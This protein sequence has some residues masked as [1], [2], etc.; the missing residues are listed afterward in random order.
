MKQDIIPTEERNVIRQEL[1]IEKWPIFAPS[2]FRGKSREIKREVVLENGDK[3]TRKVIIGKINDTEVGVLRLSDYKIF[4][5]LVKLWE[6][7]GR[8]IKEDVNFTLHKIAGILSIIWGGKTYKEI[9][10]SLIKL[11]AIPIIWEDSFYQKETNTTEKLINCFR[12]LDDLKIFER[13]KDDQMYFAF[14]SFKFNY[15][16]I[17]N[18]LNNY[19][20]PLYLDVIL[21]F[22]K[23]ISVFLYRHL[24]LVMADKNYFE[25][26]TQELFIDLELGKYYPSRRKTLLIPVLEELEGVELTTGILS[27]AK[28]ERTVDG[29]DWKVVFRKSRKVLKIEHREKQEQTN[30]GVITAVE[31]FNKRFPQK[32]GMLKG[33]VIEMLI[34]KY[35]LDKVMLHISRIS[36][37]EVVNNPVGLLRTSLEKEWDL[38]PTRE[39][40]QNKEKQAKEQREKKE[41]EEQ[42]R[43]RGEYLKIKEEEERLNKIFFSLLE[44]EQERLKEEAR[45]IIIE[46]HIDDSQEKVSKFFLI[47]TMVMIK[48]REILKER[49]KVDTGIQG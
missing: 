30:N 12:I 5:L 13:R 21:K 47:D 40:I 1:N 18:L 24:D 41:R 11:N 9:R 31:L 14:S 38:L 37:D 48:V 33:E 6:T 3:V 7:I 28:L 42:E 20:K 29:K 32:K 49:E 8:P 45:R 2:T 19:S 35:S 10:K 43:E 36:N 46:Q 25:R 17:N 23:E 16:I 34:K 22:K 26:K 44:E 4:N 39:E 15:R 27:Y